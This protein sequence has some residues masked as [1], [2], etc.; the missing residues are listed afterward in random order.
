MNKK[1]EYVGKQ[2]RNIQKERIP[3]NNEKG[4][5]AKEYV[6]KIR[7]ERSRSKNT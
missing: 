5:I 7:I 3:R 2:G 1:K 4:M 6:R